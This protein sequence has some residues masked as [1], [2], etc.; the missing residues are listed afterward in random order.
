MDEAVRQVLNSVK[1]TPKQILSMLKEE[2]STRE[3]NTIAKQLFN[4]T[5]SR[6]NKAEL[7]KLVLHLAGES[8][9]ESEAESEEIKGEKQVS[10][11]V[12]DSESE[13]ESEK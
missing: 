7:G 4:K 6:L 12:S 10:F 5:C 13:S 11:D 2:Y 8:E 3:L 9:S 1:Q